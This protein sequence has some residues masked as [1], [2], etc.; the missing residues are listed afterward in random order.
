MGG[1]VRIDARVLDQ[2]FAGRNFGGWL[3]VFEYGGGECGA[4]DASVDVSG[5][6]DLQFGETFNRADTS[7]DFFGNF[8]GSLA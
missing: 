6:G 3:F 4:I 7:G 8:P 2:N 1:L 5:A